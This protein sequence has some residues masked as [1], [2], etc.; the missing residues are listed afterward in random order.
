MH[1]YLRKADLTEISREIYFGEVGD[2]GKPRD[3]GE[4]R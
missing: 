4:V 2:P 3:I 1:V